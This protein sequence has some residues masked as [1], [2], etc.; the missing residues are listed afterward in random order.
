[1]TQLTSPPT[2]S[3]DHKSFLHDLKFDLQPVAEG[4]R[5]GMVGTFVV[6]PEMLAPDSGRVLVGVL[7]TIADVAMGSP[8]SNVEGKS[9]VG[10][11]VDLVMR[12]FGVTG[13][14]TYDVE[15]RV[16]KRGRTISVADTTFTSGGVTIGHSLATF[17]PIVIDGP[18]A[19]P[20]PKEGARIG[21]GELD[22]P[23][24][25]ALGI[26]VEAP[27]VASVARRPYTLQP[28]GTIQGGVICTLAEV[29]AQSLLGAP[30]A[31]L[32]V[33]FLAQVKVG[34]GR[35]VAERLDD[36]TARIIVTD[37]GRDD[38][39]DDGSPTGSRPTAYAIA[40]AV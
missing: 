3:R 15:A 19:M 32:D 22:A 36:K 34:P 11:T 21:D 39:N 37:A 38:G 2:Q 24:V 33:R 9:V 5:H 25:D 17:M 7:A 14:G 10:L 8:L 16:V 27:G 29:A 28:A 23:F 26:E 30:I 1:M 18:L 12:T 6:T 31:D 35:A 20:M 13:P 40:R 4:P